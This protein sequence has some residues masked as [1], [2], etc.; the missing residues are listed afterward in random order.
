MQQTPL[1]SKLAPQ[2]MTVLNLDPERDQNHQQ[3]KFDFLNRGTDPDIYNPHV[4][5]EPVSTHQLMAGSV[6]AASLITGLNSD[7]PASSSPR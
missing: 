1:A 7:L 5:Q 3:R 6:I 2:S 4:L